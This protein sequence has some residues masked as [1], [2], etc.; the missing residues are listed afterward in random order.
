MHRV[1]SLAVE[2]TPVK[3]IFNHAS[4]FM[5]LENALFT[6]NLHSVVGVH[7]ALKRHDSTAN[8]P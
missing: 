7:R 5:H 1:T 2:R 4:I 8:M 3:I 6:K